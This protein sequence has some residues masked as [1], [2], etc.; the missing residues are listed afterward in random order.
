MM[1]AELLSVVKSCCAGKPSSVSAVNR[2]VGTHTRSPAAA[3]T[4]ANSS[5]VQTPNPFV[6]AVEAM[7]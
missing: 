6:L 1:R 7:Q 5:S 4:A 3:A 2:A